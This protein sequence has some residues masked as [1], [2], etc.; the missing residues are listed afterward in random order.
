MLDDNARQEKSTRAAHEISHGQM[1]A[2]NNADILWGWGTPAGIERAERRGKLISQFGKLGPGVH[3]LELGCGSGIFTQMFDQTGATV[4]AVD[5][6]PDLIE[7][8]RQRN[9]GA[10]FICGSFE[11]QIFEQQ[12]DSIVGSSVLHHLDVDAALEKCMALLK[13]GGVIAF[14]E[15]NLINPQIFAERT[16]LRRLL[17]QV[18]PDE[19]AFVRWNLA[20]KLK[21]FG[22]SQI[23][24]IPFDWLHPA[25][26]PRFISSVQILGNVI[27]K[28]PVIREFSGSLLISAARPQAS[29]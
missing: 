20:R 27:E 4:V 26:P 18:S 24:I 16:F 9:P 21:K 23:N 7:I 12:F 2:A 1:L 8:A 13:P 14:A 29:R 15:P 5:I 19:T 10:S 6:S 28:I 11:D 25:I 3:T 22:F 17:P